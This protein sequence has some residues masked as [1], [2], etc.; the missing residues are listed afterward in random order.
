MLYT[1]E[2]VP[3]ETEPKMWI[4]LSMT[5]LLLKVREA[6]DNKT[7]QMFTDPSGVGSYQG[8]CAIGVGLTE[9]E[10]VYGDNNE[11]HAYCVDDNVRA[12]IFI[13][14]TPQESRDA[15]LLQ[16]A[17][18]NSLTAIEENLAISRNEFEEVLK[19]LES[20]YRKGA[21]L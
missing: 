10:R 4:R 1:D 14:P 7:L 20:K 8:P 21:E 5:E 12:G 15:Q 6:F 13:F 2:P 9:E 17:H 11:F 16:N 19:S 3:G 18:D